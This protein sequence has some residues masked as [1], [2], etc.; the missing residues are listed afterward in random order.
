MG[1]KETERAWEVCLGLGL[2]MPC[3]LHVIMPGGDGGD[4]GDEM[5][6]GDVG[7]EQRWAIAGP[8]EEGGSE[9]GLLTIGPDVRGEDEGVRVFGLGVSAVGEEGWEVRGFGPKLVLGPTEGEHGFDESWKNKRGIE[10]SKN[11][12]SRGVE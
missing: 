8:V 3:L 9:I 11:S 4:K 5:D 2:K 6:K 12:Y 7:P 10:S 1:E